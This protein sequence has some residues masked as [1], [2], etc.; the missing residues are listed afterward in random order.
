M[1]LL[2]KAGR[3]VNSFNRDYPAAK[4]QSVSLQNF[5][6]GAHKWRGEPSL[7]RSI[8]FYC[9][10]LGRA[11]AAQTSLTYSRH[12]ALVPTLPVERQPLGTGVG[13]GHNE[14]C[15]LSFIRTVNTMFSSFSTFHISMSFKLQNDG[16]TQARHAQYFPWQPRSTSNS[17]SHAN[18]VSGTGLERFRHFSEKIEGWCLILSSS[19][20]RDSGLGKP[21][22]SAA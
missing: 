11:I 15:S 5:R 12:S 9:F 13:S 4:A 3:L 18:D 2:S 7:F 10:L 20:G 14:Y 1:C 6:Q 8:A 16:P 21:F 22:I 19:M 17:K